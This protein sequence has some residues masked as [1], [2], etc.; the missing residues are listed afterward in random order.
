MNGCA[1]HCMHCVFRA[2]IMPSLNG[3]GGG[4]LSCPANTLQSH[5]PHS[6]PTGQASRRPGHRT[7]RRTADR[8][9]GTEMRGLSFINSEARQATAP[10]LLR[11][12]PRSLLISR[13]DNRDTRTR[14]RIRFENRFFDYRLTCLVA[15]L[16]LIVLKLN[17]KFV[18]PVVLKKQINMCFAMFL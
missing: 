7:Q 1:R 18:I 16:N 5:R 2:L 6:R 15:I 10:C 11:P 12:M 4:T 9:V 17:L 3:G 13:I 8:E 14:T